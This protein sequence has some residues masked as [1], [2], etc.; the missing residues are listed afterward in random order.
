[1]RGGQRAACQPIRGTR[2]AATITVPSRCPFK[3]MAA[4]HYLINVSRA[5]EKPIHH[6]GDPLHLPPDWPVPVTR[7]GRQPIP[8]P[9]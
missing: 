7:R 9:N 2:G 4:V 8:V 5:T 6:A 3:L 1:M